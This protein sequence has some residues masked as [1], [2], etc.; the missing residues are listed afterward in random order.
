MNIPMIKGINDDDLIFM[1]PLSNITL[2]FHGDTD[3]D[4]DFEGITHISFCDGSECECLISCTGEA[5]NIA[6]LHC[7]SYEEFLIA[8]DLHNCLFS[9]DI[10]N[11]IKSCNSLS[12]KK[13][14][15]IIQENARLK[16]QLNDIKQLLKNT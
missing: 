4:E 3:S 9:V 14:S 12:S 2:I 1:S 16:K 8:L 7:Y 6:Q 13:I 15:S 5:I 10:E 11:T